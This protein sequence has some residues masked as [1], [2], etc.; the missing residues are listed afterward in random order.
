MISHPCGIDLTV[1][2]AWD[3]VSYDDISADVRFLSIRYPKRSRVQGTFDPGMCR[4]VLANQARKYDP[5]NTAGPFYGELKPNRLVQIDFD[6]ASPAIGQSKWFGFVDQFEIDYDQS[7]KDSTVTLTCIDQLA[8]IARSVIPRGQTFGFI[9]SD[10]LSWLQ[11]FEAAIT[12]TRL[13]SFGNGSISGNHVAEMLTS[14]DLDQSKNLLDLVRQAADLEQGMIL[15]ASDGNTINFFHRHWFAQRTESVTS[16]ASVGD[17]GLPVLMLKP[18]FDTQEIVTAVAM[19]DQ[20]GN[21]VVAIDAAG[22]TTYGERFPVFSYDNMPAA[23][24]ETLEGAANTML[25]LNAGET[26]RIE[27]LS[28]RPAA[29]DG[30]L[31]H[32]VNRELLDRVTVTYTPTLTGSPVVAAYFIDGITHDISPADWVSSWSLMPAAPY[33]AALP[34]DLFIVGTSLVDGSD[35]VGF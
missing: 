29:D 33:D 4:I 35:L 1:K 21:T 25:A 13:P 30:W 20:S 22:V 27:E 19:S 7:N 11:S 12:D 28:F 17:G 23:G 3:D 32:V 16:Q 9:A 34:G 2:V 24:D 26:F 8:Y 6:A 5:L 10:S 15:S 18:T 14:W 31:E